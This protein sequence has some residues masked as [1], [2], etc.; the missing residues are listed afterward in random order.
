MDIGAARAAGD[1]LRF[2]LTVL[3]I[4]FSWARTKQNGVWRQLS[5]MEPR[6]ASWEEQVVRVDKSEGEQETLLSD[7]S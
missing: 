5:Q 6:A 1:C 4:N 3:A 2:R 7:N